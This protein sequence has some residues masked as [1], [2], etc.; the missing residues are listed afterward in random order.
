MAFDNCKPGFSV[1]NDMYY[2]C[3][4]RLKWLIF[5]VDG[6][7]F[8]AKPLGGLEGTFVTLHHHGPIQL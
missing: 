7:T 5:E 1:I 6:V 4:Y 3:I 8:R 2:W